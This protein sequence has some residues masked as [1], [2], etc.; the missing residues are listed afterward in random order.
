M[1]HISLAIDRNRAA[2]RPGSL[3]DMVDGRETVALG[4]PG[5]CF[6]APLGDEGSL[7][8]PGVL[9]VLRVEAWS[10]PESSVRPQEAASNKVGNLLFWR[11]LDG[12]VES[13]VATSIRALSRLNLHSDCLNRTPQCPSQLLL[14]HLTTHKS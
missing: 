7:A 8:G 4:P 9:G 3:V 14:Y 13:T 12:A 5:D 6:S 10:R 1:G 2:T 11:R